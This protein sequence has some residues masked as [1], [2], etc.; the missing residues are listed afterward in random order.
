MFSPLVIFNTEK[1]LK[2]EDLVVDWVHYFDQALEM[3]VYL[4]SI[5]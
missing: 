3:K 2:L 5:S 4:V 1:E